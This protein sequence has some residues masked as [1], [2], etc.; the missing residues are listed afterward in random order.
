[1]F[2]LKIP[3]LLFEKFPGLIKYKSILL[4]FTKVLFVYLAFLFLKFVHR[5]LISSDVD[6]PLSSYLKNLNI[7]AVGADTLI[8]PAQWL[9]NLIGYHTVISERTISIPGFRGIII[10][11]PCLGFNVFSLFIALIIAYPVRSKPLEKVLFILS[12]I[13]IIQLLNILRISALVVLNKY[14]FPITYHHELFNLV[15]YGFVFS[16]FYIWINHYSKKVPEAI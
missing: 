6:S 11:A 14:S 7:Y 1:M 12:G 4:F 15:I 3:G 9:L 16:A 10:H 13:M 5:T 2:P 8:Y